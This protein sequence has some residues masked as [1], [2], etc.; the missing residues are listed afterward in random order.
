MTHFR[1]ITAVNTDRPASLPD[2]QSPPAVVA[3]LPQQRH[4]V[5]R[6]SSFSTGNDLNGPWQTC[7]VPPLRW[8]LC[9]RRHV[10]GGQLVH[11]VGELSV[12]LG[13]EDETP[14]VGHDTVSQDAYGHGKQC[15]LHET[16]ESLVVP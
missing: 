10:G 9:Q 4:T 13:P 6:W 2:I 3:E 8:A 16:N 1:Q 11:A 15:F 7:P 5:K 14:M 12:H